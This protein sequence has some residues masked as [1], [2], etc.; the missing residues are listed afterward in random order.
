MTTKVPSY[1][2]DFYSDDF[3]RDP[4]PHYAAMRALGPVVFIPSLG[5]YAFTQHRVVQ[6]GLRDHARFT[7]A[8]GVAGHKE[9]FESLLIKSMP[10][11]GDGRCFSDSINTDG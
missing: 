10:E 7:S 1:D 5:N 2:V 9:G 3:I 11:F 8:K 4:H 6:D